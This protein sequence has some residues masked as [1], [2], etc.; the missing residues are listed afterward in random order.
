M[1]TATRRGLCIA[2]AL[3]VTVSLTGLAQASRVQGFESGDPAVTSIGDAGKQGTYQSQAPPEGTMQFLLT[4]IGTMSN[5][6]NVVPQSGAPAVGNSALQTFFH[7]L[8]LGGFEGSGVLIPFTVST[9]DTIL[10][11]QYD[12]LSNEPFQSMPRPDFAFSAVFDASNTLVLS[13]DTFAAVG[14]SNLTPFNPNQSPFQF[15]TGLNTLALPLGNL[16]PGNY[17]LAVG[18]EDAGTADHASGVLIDNV[19][20]VPEPSALA[21]AIGGAGLLVALRRRL[22]GV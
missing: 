15:H 16:T 18:V 2:L 9:G 17:V 10:T 19:Q 22:R 13:P 21:L 11:F 1:R 5:E 4:T 14:T 8:P 12:F 7:G 20:L 3:T 6:D